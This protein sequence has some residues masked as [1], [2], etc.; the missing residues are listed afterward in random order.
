MINLNKEQNQAT[1]SKNQFNLVIAGAGTGK[2]TVIVS[3]ILKLLYDDKI[4]S[5]EIVLL[6]FSNK[7]ANEMKTRIEESGVELDY[8][9][10]FHSVSL[11]L[12]NEYNLLAYNPDII[13]GDNK[14]EFFTESIKELQLK[15][16]Y[17]Q[18]FLSQIEKLKR[19][20]LFYNEIIPNK[21]NKM[22]IFLKRA[23]ELYQNA[24]IKNQK[25]DYED[26]LLVL[27]KNI[28]NNPQFKEKFAS[29][30]KH[31]LVDEYQDSSIL[32][33]NLL[34]EIL[35]INNKIN[36]FAVGDDDQSIYGFRDA[37]IE[38][39]LRFEEYFKGAKV[40]KL[41]KNYRSD[42]QIVNLANS[43][44]KNNKF[45][46]KKNVIADLSLKSQKIK[47]RIEKK[48]FLERN[49]ENIFIVK[50]VMEFLESNHE[51][52]EIAILFRY[53]YQ[54]KELIPYFK[55]KNIEFTTSLT[56]NEK[57]ELE[58]DNSGKGVNLITYHGA[59][60]LEFQTVFLTCLETE[61]FLKKD[62]DI[63]EERRLFYVGITRAKENLFLTNS[64]TVK[65][66]GQT[67]FANKLFFLS[68][69]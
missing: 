29:M 55:Q 53:K 63:E 62:S 59:K 27:I 40:T 7:A 58:L 57:I 43:L 49:E 6:T 45:R 28:K 1:N 69:I 61:T 54:L 68:E 46:Y 31:I 32:Q 15:E 3:R 25:I 14:L 10:T 56:D 13:E 9:G 33:L 50:K 66:F 35:N 18:P 12:I 64:T 60:G 19:N 5:S 4:D 16:N 42:E 39:I 44:I 11:K 24:L 52:S 20:G 30:F 51:S 47:G 48:I 2:T 67:I 17:I 36:I 38:N 26:M 41:I 21:A 8:A 23:Y 65:R 34:R 22:E 37:K